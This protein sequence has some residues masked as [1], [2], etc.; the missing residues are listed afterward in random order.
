LTRITPE[1]FRAIAPA[2]REKNIHVNG[3]AIALIPENAGRVAAAVAELRRAATPEPTP[4]ASTPAMIA[5]LERSFAQFVTEFAALSRSPVS[6]AERSQL[7]AVLCVALR[8]LQRLD[9]EHR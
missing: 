7:G 6:L 9:L 8:T 4:P 2:V 1:Q 5:A 3:Q